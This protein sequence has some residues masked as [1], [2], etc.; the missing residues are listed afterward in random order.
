MDAKI[1]RKLEMGKRVLEW[2]RAHPDGSPGH[3][4][5]LARLED[6]LQR[7]DRLATQQREGM[8]QV[9]MATLRKRDL[10]RE[11]RRVHLAHLA[12]VAEMASREVPDLSQ[13][14]VLPSKVNTYLAFRTA[15][16]AMAAEAESR[17]ELLVRH[18]LSEPVLEALKRDLDQF[19]AAVEDGASARVSHVGASAELDEV[20][21]EV[22]Q[23]VK[24]MDGLTRFHFRGQPELLAAW[25]SASNVIAT[26]RAGEAKAVEVKPAA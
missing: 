17:K 2:S 6:R 10:R 8:L 20:A 9:R 5:A 18:G 23:I 19:E 1:R 7:A 16:R 12:S 26:P 3:A 21:D 11:I 22:V 15:A 13:K 4:A 14:F 25:E 24:V